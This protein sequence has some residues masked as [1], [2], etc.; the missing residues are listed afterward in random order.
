M[1]PTWMPEVTWERIRHLSTAKRRKAIMDMFTNRQKAL[2]K[3]GVQ[4]VLS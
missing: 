3:E 2:I 1:K 4:S